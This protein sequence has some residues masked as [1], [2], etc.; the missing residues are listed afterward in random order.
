MS[1]VINTGTPPASSLW[2]AGEREE[3]IVP[4]GF[5]LTGG[6][7]SVV[8]WVV[9]FIECVLGGW[10]RSGGVSTLLRVPPSCGEREPLRSRTHLRARAGG[11]KTIFYLFCS[12]LDRDCTTFKSVYIVCV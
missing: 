2:E 9:A 10:V 12:L 8:H 3:T 1:L 11:G 4:S 7:T 5:S 6:V